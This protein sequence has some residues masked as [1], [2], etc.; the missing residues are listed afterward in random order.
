[1]EAAS[2]PGDVAFALSDTFGFPIDL[3]ELMANE[4]GMKV[5]M[6]KFKELLRDQQNRSRPVEVDPIAALDRTFDAKTEF[7]GFDH[8]EGEAQI[9]ER[10]EKDGEKFI[11]VDRSPFYAEMGG[12][13]GDTGSVFSNDREI[14]VLNT[15]KLGDAFCLQVEDLPGGEHVRL[16]VDAARRRDIERHHSATHL[17][18]WALHEVVSADA[19]QQG[20]LVTPDRLRFD[21]NSKA[22][23]PAQV[24]DI[25]MLV[26][27]RIVENAPVSWV[28]V[29]HADIK[30]RGDIMQFFGDKYGDLVR[31]VQIG[32]HAR[33][34]DWYSMELCG[35]T[36]VRHTGEIGLFK[37]KGEG[38]IASGVRRV[39]AVCGMEAVRY[40]AGELAGAGDRIAELEA[41]LLDAKKTLEKDR[42][43]AAQ[44][45]ADAALGAI[46]EKAAAA[47]GG[48]PVV[49][50]QIEGD[51]AALQEFLNGAKKRQFPGV[52]VFA[53]PDGDRVHIGIYVHESKT[54]DFQAGK[55]MAQL[56]PIVGGK[57]G[58]KPEM[59][60]GAG[61]D[62]S[63]IGDLLAAARG[64]AG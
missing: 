30:G 5:D 19:A 16:H 33:E 35:G 22:L 1:M 12:Q 54:G 52:A 46:F 21:F 23:T 34:L 58:G 63:K 29:P 45:Q 31:V 48:V 55:L 8:I 25:E 32:G 36:H 10:I 9:L 50:E 47:G 17:F 62:A 14:R 61:S 59:A 20:S 15:T 13:V 26:N 11:I 43:A 49:A 24:R 4:R 51:P 60:R 53:L 42:A 64:I 41:Q 18:H 57:G 40:L 56:A 7:F 44:R 37:V 6:E 38:A 28:E 39:E 3:T 27:E 2:S